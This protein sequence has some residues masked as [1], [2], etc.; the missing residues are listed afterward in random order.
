MTLT[1]ICR[2]PYP[3]A[4]VPLALS[5]AGLGPRNA[6]VHVQG[7]ASVPVAAISIPEVEVAGNE[8]TFDFEDLQRGRG[9][10]NASTLLDSELKS[11][12][13]AGRDVDD[14]SAAHHKHK[15]QLFLRCFRHGPRG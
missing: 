12:P 11:I 15:Q 10:P 9:S 8:L 1:E 14:P 4:G 13:C 5:G 7:V 3:H 6:H 2:P